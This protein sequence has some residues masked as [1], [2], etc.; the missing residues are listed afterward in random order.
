MFNRLL[1]KQRLTVD[2]GAI[3]D[4]QLGLND[5]QSWK[6]FFAKKRIIDSVIQIGEKIIIS[7]HDLDERVIKAF[8]ELCK[9]LLSLINQQKY[10]IGDGINYRLLSG[11]LKIRETIKDI[12]LWYGVY[13]EHGENPDLSICYLKDSHKISE[14]TF[15]SIKIDAWRSVCVRNK[16]I[17]AAQIFQVERVFSLFCE[18]IVLEKTHI[19]DFNRGEVELKKTQLSSELATLLDE[20]GI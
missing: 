11:N 18:N 6:D 8:D 14:D 9:C 19:E 12:K 5:I 4:K 10:H 16:N 3:I 15:Y 17:K 20:F 1:A 13:G 7:D 2:N